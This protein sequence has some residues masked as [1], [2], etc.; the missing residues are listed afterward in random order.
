MPTLEALNQLAE[1]EFI[2]TLAG[3]FEHSPWVAEQALTARPFQSLDDLHKHMQNIVRQSPEQQRLTLIRNHPELAGKEAERGELTQDS[4][5]EQAGAGLNHC[6]AE[7]LQQLRSLNQQYQDK[8]GFPFVIAVKGL[9]RYDILEA[10]QQRI[11]NSYEQE[12]ANSIEQIGRIAA[13]RLRQLIV[14]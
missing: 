10:M 7:E 13:F 3:I 4:K 2:S 8:F 12:F 11:S 14:D 5:N 6:S 1:N 9:T